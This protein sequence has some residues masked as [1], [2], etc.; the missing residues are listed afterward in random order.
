MEQATARAAGSRREV[1]S[2]GRRAAAAL[3]CCAALAPAAAQ[4]MAQVTQDVIAAEARAASPVRM[5]IKAS[6]L[7]RLENQ[8]SGF[9]APRLDLSLLPPSRSGMGVAL[10]MSGFSPRSPGQPQFGTSRTQR[11]VLDLGLT[12]RHTLE[13]DRQIDITA[14]RRMNPEPDAYTL[15]QQREPVYGARVEMGLQPARKSRLLA[16][17]GFIGLQLQGGARISIK[18]KHGGPMIYYRRTF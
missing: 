12:Y 7:P 13:S 16:D 4:E 3:G 17:L 2:W 1:S 9:Q 5:E 15:I 14:W 18:R 8:D 11:P 6:A 10:G